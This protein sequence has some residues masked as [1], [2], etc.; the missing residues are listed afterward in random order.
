M[1]VILLFISLQVFG[2]L[3]F[4]EPISYLAL[5]DSYTIGASVSYED[6]WPSQLYDSLALLGFEI[7]TLLYVATTGWTTSDLKNA[8]ATGSIENK[9]NMVSLLIGVNNQYRG[10]LF[11][12]YTED[13][14][15]LV[16]TA[17][18]FVEGDKTHFF[19]VSIPDYA[20][21]PF[22][23][24]R[25]YISSEIDS[26][27]Q[28]AKNY[29]DSLKIPYYNITEISRRGLN[30]PILVAPDGLH[31]SGKQYSLWVDLIISSIQKE[32]ITITQSRFSDLCLLSPNPVKD[33]LM[34]HGVGGKYEI[35]NLAGVTIT[36]GLSS[37]RIDVSHF[38]PGIYLFK[39][40]FR[41]QRFIKL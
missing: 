9:I 2:Q 29:C 37:G 31:P 5:G 33:V 34:V 16:E 8:I 30:E 32:S 39:T 24:G 23:G 10:S 4:D 21:T 26:Y 36:T 7:D 18:R 28:F 3:Q 41:V 25:D 35:S 40:G 27:N 15:E 17:L 12:V 14:P 1:R 19:V 20:F 13:F 6:R 22:G 11:S 38:S